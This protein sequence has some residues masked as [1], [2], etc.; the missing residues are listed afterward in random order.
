MTIKVGIDSGTTLT[1]FAI[2]TP[3]GKYSFVTTHE[4][5][6]TENYVDQLVFQGISRAN[7]IGIGEKKG[8]DKLRL[9]RKDGDP[10]DNELRIQADGAKRLLKLNGQTLD[11]SEFFLASI[12]TGT[13]YVIV[14][15]NGIEKL[16]FGRPLGGGFILGMG[17]MT[18]VGESFQEVERHASSI[19]ISSHLDIMV[20][21]LV[22]ASE[23][24]PSDPNLIV[25]NF[26]KAT[27]KSS[28]ARIAQTIIHCVASNVA[29][30]VCI[31]GEKLARPKYVVYI[32]TPVACSRVLREYLAFYSDVMGFI[33]VFPKTFAG[34][35]GALGALHMND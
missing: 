17:R 6:E 27:R 4:K 12:G 18:G 10:I 34:Y 31:M 20:S 25:S 23:I 7:F 8:L 35:A 32:G 2:Q 14:R 28:P 13:S 15:E 5:K 33:P 22:P 19:R 1:K 26:G 16:Q 3:D 11:K 29:Q 21:D 30:D 9:I 24:D